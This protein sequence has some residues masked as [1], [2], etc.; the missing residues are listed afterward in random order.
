MS[1]LHCSALFADAPPVHTPSVNTSTHKYTISTHQYTIITP[2]H[3]QHQLLEIVSRAV[4]PILDSYSADDEN[5]SFFGSSVDQWEIWTLDT[6]F[7]FFQK[8]LFLPSH[9]FQC[10]KKAG[11]QFAKNE[12]KL[13]YS[14]TQLSNE[15]KL[16]KSICIVT[17]VQFM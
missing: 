7:N 17:W 1:F 2:V 14:L 5:R 11:L 8:C 9:C 15:F 3:I 13:F 16:C 6:D 10:L 12:A 4:T